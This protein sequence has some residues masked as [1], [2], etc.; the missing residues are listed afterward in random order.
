MNCIPLVQRIEHLKKA[1]RGKKVLHLGCTDW[2]YTNEAIEAGTQLHFALAGIAGELWG[3]DADQE[4]LDYFKTKGFENLYRADLEELD[5]LDL[6]E[7]FDVIIAGEM[8]EHLSNP[9]LFLR[10]IKRF[11]RPDTKLIITTINAYCGMRFFYYGLR[12]RGGRAEP[13]HPD[14][15]Y[16]FSYSTLRHLLERENFKETDFFFYDIGK[17]HRP[18][19]RFYLNWINDICV[20]F[21]HQLADGIIVEC[22]LAPEC[23]KSFGLFSQESLRDKGR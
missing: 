16:Y 6:N 19:N 13:V 23:D 17:E 1:S 8:I 9:G 22:K 11:M 15:V 12:G 5:E 7:T 20:F 4:G 3:F 2:P 21:S 10:G 18:Y 14:H